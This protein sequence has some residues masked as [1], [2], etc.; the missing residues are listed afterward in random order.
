MNYEPEA[1]IAPEVLRLISYETMRRQGIVP[2]GLRDGKLRLAMVNKS[3]VVTLDDIRIK[4]GYELEIYPV[5]KE[6]LDRI[7][8]QNF[9][10]IT[11]HPVCPAL[12]IDVKKL[13]A[14]GG[15][16]PQESYAVQSVDKLLGYF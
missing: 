16:T 5:S 6:E 10:A 13:P 8:Q 14:G 15:A 4:T 9:E 7:L 12:A 1:R 2:L 3:D 11:E